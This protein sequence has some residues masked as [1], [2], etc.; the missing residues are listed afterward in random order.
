M[1]KRTR[2]IKGRGIGLAFRG[3]DQSTAVFAVYRSGG[4]LGSTTGTVGSNYR[5]SI[6]PDSGTMTL[7][8]GR[9]VSYVVCSD[10]YG[11]I[12]V[13]SPRHFNFVDKKDIVLI[14]VPPFARSISNQRPIRQAE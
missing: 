13:V 2:L 10:G 1:T 3:V 8:F 9:R 14:T 12:R 5:R 4:I 7:Q 11:F 6:S